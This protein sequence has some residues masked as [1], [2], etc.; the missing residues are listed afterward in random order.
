[1]NNQ[2]LKRKLW[3][4]LPLG[5]ITLAILLAWW[6]IASKPQPEPVATQEKAWLVEVMPVKPGDYAPNL[7]L[8]GRVDSLWTTR[9]SAVVEAEVLTVHHLAGDAVQRGQLLIQLDDQEA[10]LRLTQMTAQLTEAQAQVEAEY[11]RH[12]ANQAALPRERR[13]LN[14]ARNEEQRLRN[15]VAKKVTTQSALDNAQQLV[16]QRA[17]ALTT[18]EQQITEHATRLATA[19]ARVA[20][21]EAGQQQA[22]L[23]VQHCQ[24]KAPFNGIISQVTI[25]PG[26]RVRPS[27]VMLH[28]YDTDAWIIR[29]PVPERYTAHLRQAL[30]AGATLV[31]TGHLEDQLVQGKLDRLGGEIAA[32]TDSLEAIFT[33]QG[34]PQD[35]AQGQFIT[36]H[37]NLPVLR[38]V[39]AI[40]PTALYG[41]HQ[42]YYLDQTQRLQPITVERLGESRQPGQPPRILVRSPQLQPGMQL[43]VTQLPQ[44]VT[45]LLVRPTHSGKQP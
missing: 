11:I 4:L 23:A 20:Q 10:Q 12:Q 15:L 24:I 35:L 36:L 34:Q 16:Q 31:A 21:A 22:M 3:R 7:T 40:P 42:L 37:L 25:S 14:L 39:I 19:Q 2:T 1:M 29:T 44:A 18:R 5:I 8:Y 41:S 6:L 28:I 33:I 27:E 26:Q 30:T 13:L 43:V 32:S 45:G 9:L 17:I 38:D